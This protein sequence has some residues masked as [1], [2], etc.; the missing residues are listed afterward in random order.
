MTIDGH[1]VADEPTLHAY[2]GKLYSRRQLEAENA[3]LRSA[4]QRIANDE[5]EKGCWEVVDC[6]CAENIARKALEAKDER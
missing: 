2:R 6:G 4:L 5:H 1:A 3:R